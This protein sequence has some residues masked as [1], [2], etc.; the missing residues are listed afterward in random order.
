[1]SVFGVFLVL[2]FPHPDWIRRDTPYLSVFNLNAGKYGPEKLRIRTLFTH[3]FFRVSRL[4]R[5]SKFSTTNP[6]SIYLFKANNRSTRKICV[7]SSKLTIKTPE[8]RQW[9]YSS[10]FVTNFEQTS[11]CSFQ[12]WLWISKWHPPWV[13]NDKKFFWSQ[14][15]VL[16]T[17]NTIDLGTKLQNKLNFII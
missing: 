8:K 16:V 10:V 4:N 7:I 3:Y 14:I 12:C 11:H 15:S 13:V 5:F 1:M 2:I 9:R 17:P 6:A